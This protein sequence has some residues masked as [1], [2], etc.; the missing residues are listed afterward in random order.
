[1]RTARPLICINA[2]MSRL[3][4][5]FDRVALSDPGALVG[6]RR[7]VATNSRKKE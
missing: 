4:M 1:M 5:L 6:D 7:S 2:T 3:N